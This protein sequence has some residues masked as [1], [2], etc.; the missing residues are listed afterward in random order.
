MTRRK[1]APVSAPT[2]LTEATAMIGQYAVA[3]ATIERT[4]AHYEAIIAQLLAERDAIIEPVETGLKAHFISLRA[5]WAV[6]GD[7]VTEGKR[8]TAEIAGCHLGL[9]TNPPSLKLPKTNVLDAEE[10]I[11]KLDNFFGEQFIVTT[12]KLDKPA[13]IAA[14][15]DPLSHEQEALVFDMHLG[16]AQ[17]DVFFIDRVKVEAAPKSPITAPDDA[18]ENDV[19]ANDVRANEVVS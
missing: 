1:S 2:S 4:R 14:L 13:L 10:L 8:K 12:R 17:S 3:S 7:S 6:A 16:T 15:R 18:L 19:V 11:Q 5:W 9:R